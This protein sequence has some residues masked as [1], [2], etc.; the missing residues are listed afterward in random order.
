MTDEPLGEVVMAVVY[1]LGG[2]ALLLTAIL[3]RLLRRSLTPA[4]VFVA[5]GFLSAFLPGARPFHP[6]DHLVLVEHVTE[7]C[8]IVALMGVGLALDRPFSIRGWSS[9]WR[10]LIVAMPLFIAIL[11]VAAWGL[12][13]LAPAAAL[14]LASVLAPTDPVLAADV[15]VGEPTDDPRSEDELRFALS[16][17]AGAND[18]LAFPFV[19]A[20][21]L[22]LTIPVAEWLGGWVAWELIGKVVLG[23]ACGVAIGYLFAQVAFRAPTKVLRFA[24]TAESVVSLAAVFLAYG[25][26]ELV[27]GYGFLSVFA[28]GLALRAQERGH[29]FHRTMHDFVTQMERL[30]TM[31]LLLVFGYSLGSGLLADLTW[32]GALLGLAAVLVVRP[33]VGAVA[34]YRSDVPLQDRRSIA[35]FGVRGIGSFYYLAFALGSAQFPDP[36]LLWSTVAFT[37]LVSVVVH[38]T[39]AAPVLR[40][41][42]RRM[43]RRTPEPV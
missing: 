20:S 32:Q 21:V 16:S 12:V 41:I 13:G 19:H 10:L 4:M 7:L 24:E 26:A 40:R 43:G 22:L 39:T 35:F 36:G 30:L 3:P 2:V 6:Q 42:D 29:E 5:A 37:V 28:A 33:F 23:V 38:G 27:G 1:V 34:M 11:G 31:G 15:R 9:T 8:V 17:E 25:L 18:G 14:L